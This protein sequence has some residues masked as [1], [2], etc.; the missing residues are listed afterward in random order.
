MHLLRPAV[1]KLSRLHRTTLWS[2]VERSLFAAMTAGLTLVQGLRGRWIDVA[3]VRDTVAAAWWA[4]VW[5]KALGVKVVYE[6][7]DLEARNPSRAKEAWAQGLVRKMDRGGP[8]GERARRLLDRR[9]PAPARGRKPARVV[10][11][12]R[13]IPDAF[14]EVGL[15]ARRARGPRVAPS[16]CPRP[17]PSWST[18]ASPSLI[19][20]SSCSSRRSRR[21]GRPTPTLRA[22]LVGGRPAEIA[23]LREQALRLGLG[24]GVVFTG[25]RPQDE[26]VRYLQAADV[27]AIPDTVTDVT[28]SPL[29]LFEYLA[30]GRAVVLPDTRR[31]PGDPARGDRATTSAAATRPTS[32]P[33]SIGPSATRSGRDGS[34]RARGGAAPHLCGPGRA[35]PRRRAGGVLRARIAVRVVHYNLTTTTKEGGVETFVWD[36]AR[37]QARR[38]HTVR[39]VSGEGPVRRNAPGVEVRTAA[40]LPRERFALGPL[41]RAWAIRKLLERLSM[42]RPGLRLLEGAELVHIHKPYDLPLGPFLARRRVPL[43]YHGHGEGFFP[44]DTWLCRYADTL[45]SCSTYNAS[46]LRRRYARE[47]TVVYNGVDVD[48]FQP[49]SADPELRARL[50][51]G[52]ERAGPAAGAL[53][54]LEGTAPRGSRPGRATRP[55]R[56]ARSRR[57]R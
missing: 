50:L 21:C 15:P 35:H 41:R 57:G 43:V 11:R 25:P 55:L 46:T 29:K 48:R 49:R 52:A 37:E 9:L 51:G 54:A 47:P 16:A 45:L 3:Y 28:A 4:A 18:R 5:G 42:L 20:A 13:S 12:L 34:G 40:F 2:Y 44:G 10:T 7:H 38:G 23:A 56:E 33:P 36:L 17:H 14:D 6:A 27:L 19:A 53:H 26:V 30:V 32:P 39:I 1:G 31:P 22:V 8:R 24:E